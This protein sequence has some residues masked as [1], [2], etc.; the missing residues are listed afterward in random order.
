MNTQSLIVVVTHGGV[1]RHQ[2]ITHTPSPL[3][4]PAPRPSCRCCCCSLR[5]LTPRLCSCRRTEYSVLVVHVRPQ[6]SVAENVRDSGAIPLAVPPKCALAARLSFALA[7]GPNLRYRVICQ[8][9][10][11]PS[12]RIQSEVSCYL[13][14]AARLSFARAGGPSLRYRAI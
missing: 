1:A 9:V 10:V 5:P 6:G 11:C 2:S 4:P 7:G 8:I 14:L 12:R 13:A 3:C